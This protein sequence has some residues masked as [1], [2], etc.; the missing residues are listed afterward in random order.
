M[1]PIADSA[2]T[3]SASRARKKRQASGSAGRQAPP[4]AADDGVETP[5]PRA[6]AKRTL[7]DTMRQ[8]PNYLRL[9]F[10]LMN[11]R[12]VPGVDKT[13]VAAAIVY[14]LLPIDFL[15]DFIPFL[16]QVDDVFLLVTSL[17]RLISSAGRKVVADHW[18]GPISELDDM[19]LH[20][21]VG[22][23]AFFLPGRMRRRLKMIGRGWMGGV[24]R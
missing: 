8:L 1:S 17:Q 16:G 18:A 21:V 15:P 5:T 14:I 24:G 10:E 2:S 3:T 19:N 12:R 20:R 4:V 23:A 22:A 7:M 9:L 13:L 6:G 11:D